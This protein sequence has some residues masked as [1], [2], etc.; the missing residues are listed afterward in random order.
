MTTFLAGAFIA[1]L[2]SIVALVIACVYHSVVDEYDLDNSMK[3]FKE[4]CKV[5][6][7]SINEVTKIVGKMKDCP[8][9]GQNVKPIKV[10]ENVGL[11]GFVVGDAKGEPRFFVFNKGV[12]RCDYEVE[13]LRENSKSFKAQG[14]KHSIGIAE[15]QAILDDASQANFKIKLEKNQEEKVYKHFRD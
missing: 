3:E 2:L 8:T 14:L 13:A 4:T 11:Y 7:W 10:Y 5:S 12:H 15:L 9:I 6:D 1:L